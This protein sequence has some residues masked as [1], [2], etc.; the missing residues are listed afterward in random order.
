MHAFDYIS[1]LLSFVYAAAITHV[2]ATA[3][4]IA[5]AFKRINFSWL[6]AG[7]M[8]SSLLAVAAW[9]IGTWDLRGVDLWTM[10]TIAFFFAV[11]CL[12]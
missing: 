6:N 7:W 3:G 5:I 2:L 9:W 11:A 4:D 10:P 12:M 1:V 8:V